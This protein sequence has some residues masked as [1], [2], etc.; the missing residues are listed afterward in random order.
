M[1]MKDPHKETIVI[2][3]GERMS[4]K[5]AVVSGT[6]LPSENGNISN[7]SIISQTPV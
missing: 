3:K 4:D 6:L 7:S 5:R 1:L 2:L